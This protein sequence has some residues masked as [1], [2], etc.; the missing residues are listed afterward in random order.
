LTVLRRAIIDS[1]LISAEERLD[2]LLARIEHGEGVL[3]KLIGEDQ[4]IR[5][6]RE[7]VIEFKQ[8]PADIRYDPQRYF[9]FELY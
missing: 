5:H 2:T 4:L 9:N 3:G 6:I 8:L 1:K 7:T